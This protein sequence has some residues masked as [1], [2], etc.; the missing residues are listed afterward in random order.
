MR[1]EIHVVLLAHAAGIC[2]QTA[3]T[4][5]YSASQLLPDGTGSKAIPGSCESVSLQA[6]TKSYH[7]VAT[8]YCRWPNIIVY[9]LIFVYR[10]QISLFVAA[11][12]PPPTD[13]AIFLSMLLQSSRKA[14]RA[15][16]AAVIGAV[17]SIFWIGSAFVQHPLTRTSLGQTPTR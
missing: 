12:N 14:V 2:A 13:G 6:P 15:S 10:L 9:I 8:Y 16:S 17:L 7:P 1:H 5:L 3:R 4:K 11:R